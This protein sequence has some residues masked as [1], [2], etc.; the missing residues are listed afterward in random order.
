VGLYSIDTVFNILVCLIPKPIPVLDFTKE[1]CPG[2]FTPLV[3]EMLW[4]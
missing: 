1:T 2:E 4:L 3:D